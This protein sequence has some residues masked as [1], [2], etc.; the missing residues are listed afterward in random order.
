LTEGK[1]KSCPNIG[2][3]LIVM[4]RKREKSN[5]DARRKK[6]SPEG[7]VFIYIVVSQTF[8]SAQKFEIDSSDEH[9]PYNKFF[10]CKRT[11]LNMQQIDSGW[12]TFDDDS[13]GCVN[14]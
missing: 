12:Q 1:K 13:S 7:W 14:G 8:L 10:A 11:A 9:L 4:G 6:L 2:Q 3:H 5:C